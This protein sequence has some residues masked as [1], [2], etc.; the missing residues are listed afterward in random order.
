MKGTWDARSRVAGSDP[1]ARAAES[2]YVIDLTM[3]GRWIF[4]AEGKSRD[5]F[6]IG[7][8]R[9]ARHWIL[10]QLDGSPDYALLVA[11]GGWQDGR[12]AFFG[13]AAYTSGW[14]YRKRTTIVRRGSDQFTLSD[15]ELAPDG[16]YLPVDRYDFTKVQ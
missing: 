11:P 14:N 15:D 6:F 8:D 9:P 2:S 13:G 3:R 16:S 12:I 4:A 7:Y 10:L 1:Q 5:F